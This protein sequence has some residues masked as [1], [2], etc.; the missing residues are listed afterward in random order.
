MKKKTLSLIVIAIVVGIALLV[1]VIYA[2]KTKIIKKDKP[3]T[4]SKE[5]LE[6]SKE[7]TSNDKGTNIV[8]YFGGN[9]D[10]ADIVKEERFISNEE[11][12][13]EIIMQELIKG[14]AIVSE[15]KPVLPKET[16]LL[17]FSIKDGIGYINLSSEAVFEMTVV[18][19]ETLLK[20]VTNSLT[21]LESVAKVMIT[22]DNQRV[23][24]LG[25]NYDISKPFSKDEIGNLKIQK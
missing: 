24:T 1:G 19:E 13:G 14:P 5:K 16:R 15:S 18:Q 2:T 9:E 21:Q 25:G 23:E 12:L 8:L 20:S 22:I 6:N 11:F 7:L 4:I 3:S 10:K 17:N